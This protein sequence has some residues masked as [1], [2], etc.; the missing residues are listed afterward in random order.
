MER[1]ALAPEFE[2][3]P[4]DPGDDAQGHHGIAEKSAQDRSIVQKL[5]P[6]PHRG[7][8]HEPLGI[9]IIDVDMDPSRV[10]AEAEP[11]AALDRQE[12]RDMEHLAA[13]EPF[14]PA[15]RPEVGTMD[16]V[17]MAFTEGVVD[18]A[19]HGAQPAIA[20]AAE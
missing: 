1:H 9:V 17:A 12:R 8:E 16:E 13:L 18:L 14:L 6:A 5:A 7:G 11:V 3:L 20:V 19:Q 2:G 10:V 4:V 15:D